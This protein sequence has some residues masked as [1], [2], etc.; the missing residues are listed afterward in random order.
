MIDEKDLLLSFY[1]NF[2]AQ[3]FL[4]GKDIR[5]YKPTAKKLFEIHKML[6]NKKRLN[7]I[8]VANELGVSQSLAR[9]LLKLYA[10]IFDL[11]YK[12]GWLE[13]VDSNGRF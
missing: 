4:K 7:Y 6:Q 12:D 3:V 8:D 5:I 13:E 9:R 11:K 10:Q 2:V 1:Q